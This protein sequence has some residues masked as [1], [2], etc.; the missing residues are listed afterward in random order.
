MVFYFC[1]C[2]CRFITHYSVVLYN[3]CWPLPNN[4]TDSCTGDPNP[5]PTTLIILL[6]CIPGT[7]C[8]GDQNPAATT[9]IILLY[10][11]PGIGCTGDPNPAPTT[12]M[13]LLYCIP[14]TGCTGDPNPAPT[15]LIILLYCIPGTGRFPA[16]PQTQTAA[17]VIRTRLRRHS[18]SYCTVFQVLAA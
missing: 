11:I 3:R 4:P 8:T 14:G 15:T 5:A 13:I 6:Y 2:C 1:F 17:Q 12:L 9:L 18:L 16:L 10:C 7:G